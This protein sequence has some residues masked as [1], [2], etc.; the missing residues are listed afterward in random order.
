MTA[1]N[2]FDPS[3]DDG[4][5]IWDMLVRR[6]IESF[7]AADWVAFADCFRVE[8]FL[9]IDAR[10]SRDPAD[11][12]LRF[13][14]VEAYGD[15]WLAAARRSAATAYAEPRRDALYRATDM[16][17]IRVAGNVATARKVF[18]DGIALARGGREV[19][20]WQS[21]FFCARIG[22]AWK[23]TGFVGYLPF[24]G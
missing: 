24:P 2:P 13:P 12:Q 4:H 3:D 14:T 11:W 17:D 5:A 21:L 1:V 18:D 10:G 15:V 19:L 8:G 20:N 16:R 6:D 22:T 7:L 23:I 9:G